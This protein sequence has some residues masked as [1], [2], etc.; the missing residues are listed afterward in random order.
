VL[1]VGGG[2]GGENKGRKRIHDGQKKIK[3]G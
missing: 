3:R 1:N 2:G